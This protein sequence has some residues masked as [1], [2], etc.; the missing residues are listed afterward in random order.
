MSEEK[1]MQEMLEEIGDIN[2]LPRAV[3][4]TYEHLDGV[5]GDLHLDESGEV[6]CH[7]LELPWKN[8]EPNIS[9][10]PLGDYV[11]KVT[12]SPAFKKDLYLILEPFPHRDG[13]RI[14]AA[15]RLTELRGCVA[16]GE[17]ITQVDDSIFLATS[18]KWVTAVMEHFNNEP[19][20]LQI[21]ARPDQPE[22]FRVVVEEEQ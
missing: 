5:A 13:F 2:N 7:S 10:L 21:I 9:C 22:N 20:L 11:C 12:Y 1:T 15:N 17:K 4:I 6:F 16:F 19:F 18:A 3:L 8:N 14:H